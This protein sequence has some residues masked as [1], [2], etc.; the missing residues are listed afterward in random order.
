[1]TVHVRPS[2]VYPDE[3]SGAAPG[4]LLLRT[5]LTGAAVVAGT[6]AWIT[7]LLIAGN[8]IQ[9]EIVPVEIWGSMAFLLGV[10]CLV[11]L[12]LSTN[13]TGGGK[14]RYIAIVEMVLF[15]PA[16]IWCPL[17]VA[18][19][20]DTPGWVIPFDLC[21]PLSMLGML[22]L[23]IAVARV[24][25]YRGLLRRQFLLCGLWLPVAGIGQAVIGDDGGTLPGTAWLGLSYGVLGLRLALTPRIVLPSPAPAEQ[26]SAGPSQ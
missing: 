9:D 6:A 20:G 7:G 1:M 15:G 16:L 12:V 26:G 18:Y 10:L 5:R 17:A 21:W 4:G 11:A 19:D 2:S 23:G 8:E 25:R 14:G 3:P 24:G 22:V 13:A